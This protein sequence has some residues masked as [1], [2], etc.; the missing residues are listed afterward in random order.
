MREIYGNYPLKRRR[1]GVC[2]W[3]VEGA[4]LRSW[5]LG[6]VRLFFVVCGQC[7]GRC[8]RLSLP[9]RELITNRRQVYIATLRATARLGTVSVAC[10]C[11]FVPTTTMRF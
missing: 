11:L 6:I 1:R 2:Q 4:N 8:V 9:A 3:Q 5:G 7:I 10:Q